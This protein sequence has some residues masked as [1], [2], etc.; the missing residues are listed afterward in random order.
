[1]F[2]FFPTR[3][4]GGSG[5][6]PVAAGTNP[7]GTPKGLWARAG[8]PLAVLLARAC[9]QVCARVQRARPRARGLAPSP[10]A[11]QAR[12]QRPLTFL[13]GVVCFWCSGGGGPLDEPQP[14]FSGQRQVWANGAAATCTYL[15]LSPVSAAPRTPTV[16]VGR[17][18]LIA[19]VA[20]ACLPAYLQMLCLL[21]TATDEE[22][23]WQYCTNSAVS[24]QGGN[25][26]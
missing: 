22:S 14:I 8:V 18:P 12:S 15:L 25:G 24:A 20:R 17:R 21:P 3:W 1:M 7:G 5:T 13:S 6:E 4:A 9:T 16:Y 19:V 11:T 10:R 26:C 2:V 23:L